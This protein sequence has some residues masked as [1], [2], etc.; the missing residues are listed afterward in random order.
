V[1]N[2][3]GSKANLLER[4]R[5]RPALFPGDRTITALWQF[6]LG[7]GFARQELGAGPPSL[8]PPDIHEW[9][10]Y[11]LHFQNSTSGWRQMILDRVPDEALALERFFEL[12]DDHHA[13]K[14]RVVAAVRERQKGTIFPPPPS[15]SSF[16]PM[17]RDSS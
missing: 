3:E 12:L 15:L 11:R 2:S 7:Y 1:Q 8:L 13:R 5:K 17:I 14:P 16:T 9:I 10:A 6:L 4:I